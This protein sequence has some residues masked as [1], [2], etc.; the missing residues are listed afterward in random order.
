VRVVTLVLAVLTFLVLLLA[1]GTQLGNLM[2]AAPAP[3]ALPD[4]SPDG[5]WI[6]YEHEE[7]DLRKTLWV[8][9]PDG[10]EARLLADPGYAPSWHPSEDRILFVRPSEQGVQPYVVAAEGG[11]PEK[12]S[13]PVLEGLYYLGG[14]EWARDGESVFYVTHEPKPGTAWRLNLRT[15]ETEQAAPAGSDSV[16]QVGDGGGVVFARNGAAALELVWREEETGE[17]RVIAPSIVDSRAFAVGAS[18]VYY[19]APGS[20]PYGEGFLRA[21]KF[22]TG[23]TRELGA[24]V[25]R[26]WAGL[27]VSPDEGTVVVSRSRR[28]FTLRAF[29]VFRVDRAR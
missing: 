17:E 12:L 16:E 27:A 6:V 2:E 20:D 4:F 8:A 28:E 13:H 24:V 15:G 22:A 11:E 14:V 21:Y 18:A 5:Q 7:A 29:Q 1:A 25:D 19:V 26:P 3:D 9:R 10:S 23:E